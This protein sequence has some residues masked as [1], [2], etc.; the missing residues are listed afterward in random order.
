MPPG[1]PVSA[2]IA[3]RPSSLEGAGTQT[4]PDPGARHSPVPAQ[5]RLPPAAP[6]RLRSA[7]RRPSLPAR[8]RRRETKLPGKRGRGAPRGAETKPNTPPPTA[9]PRPPG[10]SRPLRPPGGGA[11]LQPL[12]GARGALKPIPGPRTRIP[13][14]WKGNAGPRLAESE[15]RC[16]AREASLGTAALEVALNPGSPLMPG[17]PKRYPDNWV[18]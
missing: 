6:S 17:L 10:A 8:R 16:G 15:L 14:S 9:S 13:G 3:S 18:S 12:R 4:V 1:E 5:P 11:H 2:A 7:R